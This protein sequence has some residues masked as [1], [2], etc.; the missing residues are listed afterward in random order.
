[1]SLPTNN[2]KDG[3]QGGK[4]QKGAALGSKFIAKATK[5]ANVGKKPIKTGG[6]RGS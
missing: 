2:K 5:G 4:N 3:K 1:M 6:S